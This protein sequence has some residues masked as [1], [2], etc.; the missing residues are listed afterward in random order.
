MEEKIIDQQQTPQKSSKTTK[1]FLIIGAV[2]ICLFALTYLIFQIA[3][4]V[5]VVNT[6]PPDT[7]N[8]SGGVQ[9]DTEGLSAAVYIIFTII[10]TI[11]A[12]VF[13]IIGTIFS[14][15]GLV[16]NGNGA[17]NRKFTIWGALQIVIP[18]IIYVLGIVSMF[19]IQLV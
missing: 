3:L 9:I 7:T 15:I 18:F 4:F 12:L 19:I 6:P 17:R 2:I 13:H 14:A 10:T 5:D 8:N 1:V 11:V 16:A